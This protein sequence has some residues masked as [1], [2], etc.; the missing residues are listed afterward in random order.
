M[1]SVTNGGGI[2]ET[3]RG[4][5]N[6]AIDAYSV[7]MPQDAWHHGDERAHEAGLSSEEAALDMQRQ[8]VAA[9][10][11]TAD[12]L[13]LDFGSGVGGAVVTMAEMTG[14]RFIGIS[15]NDALTAKA[16]RLA[17]AR[18]L[19]DKAFFHSV[20][21]TEY[22]TLGAWPDGAFAAITYQESVVHLPDKQAFFNAAF[23]VLRPGGT[24]A[25]VDW[26]QR[27]WGEYRSPEQIDAVMSEVNRAFCIPYHAT[28][29]QYRDM[30]ASA[31]FTVREAIDLFPSGPCWGST[32]EDEREKWLAYEGDRNDLFHDGKVALDAA[33]AAGVF[34]V[35]KLVATKPA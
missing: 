33:R 21:D 12:D 7:M 31:G 8:L 20:G 23:R 4:Y 11:I 10:G 27:P 32:P 1:T 28:V 3:V 6:A 22:R 18:G 13:V 25:A 30:L 15:N 26:I 5:Y 19:A 34:S 2:E 17:A 16:Q 35:A 29:E 14:A 24:L 9:A